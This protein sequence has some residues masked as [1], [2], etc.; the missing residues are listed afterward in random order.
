ML[1]P[2]A[3]AVAPTD[4]TRPRWGLPDIDGDQ[5]A[6]PGADE[7]D[8]DRG[9]PA[10]FGLITPPTTGTTGTI[11]GIISLAVSWARAQIGGRDAFVPGAPTPRP[12]PAPDPG[13]A[14]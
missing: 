10:R 12:A 4:L 1:D 13:D 3:E 9:A 14:L 8:V 2:A 5:I 6:A 7:R 11:D